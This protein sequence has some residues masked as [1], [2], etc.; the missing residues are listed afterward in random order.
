[1]VKK[2]GFQFF[3][4]IF[5][6]AF[7]KAQS[8]NL[9]C[10]SVDK[11]GDVTLSWDATGVSPCAGP[12]TLDV[13]FNSTLNG[14]YQVAAT[15]LPATQISYLHVG[16]GALTGIVY[17]YIIMNCNGIP[18]APSNKLS[19]ILLR[20]SRNGQVADLSW[21]SPDPTNAV[22]YPYDLHINYPANSIKE[23]VVNPVGLT[24]QDPIIFCHPPNYTITSRSTSCS[25]ASNIKVGFQDDT[26]PPVT[27]IGTV[28]V[29]PASGKA[30]LSWQANPAG[31]TQKYVILNSTNANAAPVTIDNV[32]GRTNTSYLDMSSNP[33]SASSAYLI[34]A[35]DSCDLGSHIGYHVHHTILLKIPSDACSNA[36]NLSWNKYEGW[37]GG[38]AAYEIYENNLLIKSLDSNNT[39][40]IR[41]GLPP[42]A[43]FSYYIKAVPFDNTITSSVSNKVNITTG[44]TTLPKF[45][46]VKI[47][48]VTGDNN[49]LVTANVDVSADVNGYRLLR[50]TSPL[51]PFEKVLDVSKSAV[52]PLLIN[53]NTAL[54]Q[55]RS[56]YYK[57]QAIN[58]CGNVAFTSTNIGRSVFVSATADDDFINNMLWNS[59]NVD[60]SG[61]NLYRSVDGTWQAN[62]IK[63]FS[64][65]TFTYA[66]DVKSLLNGQGNFCYKIAAQ[67]ASN[68]ISMSNAF[69][70]IQSP[71][72]YVPN[73]FAP[74]GVN[75]IFHPVS[76]F[77]DTKSYDLSIYNRWGD[78]IFETND[79]HQGWDGSEKGTLAPQG[80]YVFM[81]YF[82]GLNGQ[83]L[84]RSGTVEMIR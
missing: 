46:N 3:F 22:P 67:T 44:T 61:Y 50:A 73:A 16:A 23:T 76:V 81:V 35:V 20:G 62:P 40:Y 79:P 37:P 6:V 74:G 66:D 56:Y 12:Q 38:V 65:G 10:T 57:V 52:S 18:G 49:V 53:D 54:T 58:S 36:A 26:R 80:V 9:L 75:R 11:N 69:C 47:V 82:T 71:R 19:T 8:P 63:M 15:N 2:T 72:L 84:K 17:Y 21:N 60:D 83:A 77:D 1:M 28:T 31:D 51:G 24:Y 25:F 43:S 55:E 13:Y 68:E 59:Y 4:F 32:N 7:S 39:S 14:V 70:L 41:A 29:D 33:S 48:S 34:V 64:A 30:Q 45:L 42:S 27:E 78:K 5:F